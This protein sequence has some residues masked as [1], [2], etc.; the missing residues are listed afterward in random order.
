MI[1]GRTF[2]RQHFTGLILSSLRRFTRGSEVTI[3]NTQTNGLWGVYQ[4]R[5]RLAGDE[6]TYRL[7]LAPENAP[8]EIGGQ[9]IGD[10]FH[11]PL[12]TM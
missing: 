10:H 9:P 8:L 7:I 1:L 4:A 11:F 5:I 12:G 3:D 6:N 2:I